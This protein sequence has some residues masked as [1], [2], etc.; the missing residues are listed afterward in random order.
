MA[1]PVWFDNPLEL[2]IQSK[3]MD[4]WPTTSQSPNERIN[5]ATRFIL[6]TAT[7]TYI[8]RRDPRIIL[9]AL[10]ILSTLF[11]VHREKLFRNGTRNPAYSHEYNYS[12]DC[13]PPSKENPMANFLLG[14]DMYR[15][16]AC[17]SRTVSGDIRAN[18]NDTFSYDCGRSR[19]PMPDQQR[20]GAAR[21]F[22]SMPVTSAVGDQ[23][24]FAEWCYGK[25]HQP[26]CRD[27]PTR[28]DPNFRGAQPEAL[29]GLDSFGIGSAR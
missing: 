20:R 22:V 10:M 26:M 16:P 23:T 17:E 7:V 5:S 8:I 15:P 21:Q 2:F 18:L 1:T 29:A 6:Y 13:Q 14:D 4:F 11:I 25:K 3:L 24:A 28:C 19:C 27:D 9:L 12:P